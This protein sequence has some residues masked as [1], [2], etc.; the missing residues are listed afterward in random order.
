MTIGFDEETRD[1]AHELEAFG[2]TVVPARGAVDLDA[3]IYRRARPGVFV[4][5]V[6][7]KESTFL[8]NVS[9]LTPAEAAAI[10]QNRLYSPLFGGLH[11][12]SSF[13]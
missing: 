3:F 1:F 2:F 8:L 6:N 10:L 7:E 11:P 13:H 4:D 5:I 12:F 9:A